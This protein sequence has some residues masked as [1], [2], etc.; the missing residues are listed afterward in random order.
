MLPATNTRMT[1]LARS[2]RA[3]ST[4]TLASGL[5]W[6]AQ[7]T[8]AQQVPTRTYSKPTAELVEPYSA[9]RG[10]RELSDGRVIVSDTRDKVVQLA[11]FK[12]G[13]ANTLGREGSGPNE[14]QMPM[15]AFA[16]PGDSTMIADALNSRFLLLGPGGKLA[17][18]WSPAAAGSGD[19][20]RTVTRAAPAPERGRAGGGASFVI[21]GG[22]PMAMLN[23]RATD[24]QGRIYMV[25]S[26][27]VVGPD[28]PKQAD[29]VPIMRVVRKTMATDT[30]AWLQ[31]PKN[32][33]SV[34]GSAGNV[35]IR[36]GGG[37]YAA[38]D[39][40]TVLADGRVVVVRH[41]DYRVEVHPA[42]GRGAPMRG[43]AVRTPTLRVG[44]AEKEAWR[45]SRRTG[46]GVAIAMTRTDGPG[47]GTTTRSAPA[48]M[49]MQEP[50][51]WPAVLPAFQGNQVYALPN[52]QIWVG[53][54]RAASDKTPRYDVFDATGKHTG[55][56]V[57]P[58][59]TNVVGFGKGVVYIV[60][61]DEDDLQYLQRYALQ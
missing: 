45:E 43:A 51:E 9:V 24:A 49:Q 20:P 13:R 14:Y 35:N 57:F 4:A 40:W 48:N 5:L 34:T 3:A 59:R 18:T 61:I 16:L 42:S 44:D 53:R 52:G 30:V 8:Q 23:T 6:S 29:S 11:D 31:L 25:G 47:G 19:E 28:G 22:G 37:P 54:Y 41:A 32:A 36:M 21:G 56:V 1:S 33:A 50:S 55:Q 12:T 60:R 7:P 26:P 58:A 10:V 27:L 2:L 15:S 17:G 39:G 46:G 38:E